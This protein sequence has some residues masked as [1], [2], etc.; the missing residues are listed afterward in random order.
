MHCPDTFIVKLY[1]FTVRVRPHLS[2]PHSL[3]TWLSFWITAESSC[4]PGPDGQFVTVQLGSPSNVTAPFGSDVQF[5]CCGGHKWT[6]EADDGYASREIGP[7][8][9][10]AGAPDKRP[11][12]VPMLSTERT[13]AIPTTVYT[14]HD[15][16][17]RLILFI[18][19][20][21]LKDTGHYRCHGDTNS[22]DAFL[23]VSPE[24]HITDGNRSTVV[25]KGAVIQR[26][27]MFASDQL[28]RVIIHCPVTGNQKIQSW[29]WREPILPSSEDYDKVPKGKPPSR[30]V[31]ANKPGVHES[32]FVEIGPR[33]AWAKIR[34]PLSPE[35]PV[36]LW[37]Q[38]ETPSP[39]ETEE[40][41]VAYYMMDWELYEPINPRVFILNTEQP[42]TGSNDVVTPSSES[43][44][45]RGAIGSS[46]GRPV[47]QPSGAA[48]VEEPVDIGNQIKHS[49]LLHQQQQQRTQQQ[50]YGQ[51]SGM[52]YP[53][54]LEHKPARLACQF[55]VVEDPNQHANGETQRV[56]LQQVYWYRNGQ[57]V[58][59]PPFHVDNS[60]VPGSGLS[61]L[62]VRAYPALF[63]P[64]A[65][66][67][68][69]WGTV[70]RIT[71]AVSSQ[72]KSKP[73]YKV[74]TNAR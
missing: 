5:I 12:G 9:D 22:V 67:N 27:V 26:Q 32:G 36:K 45:G 19:N 53:I 68:A 40:P 66:S 49:S 60:H 33:L 55:R 25:Q 15:D 46:M 39:W 47:G 23:A 62:E 52:G 59:V 54:L 18:N 20:A 11:S 34:D 13:G 70:E 44:S 24:P 14:M 7:H 50:H 41:I 10:A 58:H 72:V 71:C 35:A 43:G 3:I 51:Q 74:T 56:P 6:Y 30:T 4:Q 8:P 31:T 17:G 69:S 63:E 42:Y 21:N 57:P 65:Q 73:V 37:C 2:L 1:K 29:L 64:T 61:M 38:F 28:N 48:P 16:K